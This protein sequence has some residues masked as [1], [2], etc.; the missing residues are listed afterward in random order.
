[1]RLGCFTDIVM[2]LISHPVGDVQ[3]LPGHLS[4]DQPRLGPQLLSRIVIDVTP[5]RID[6]SISQ[7]EALAAGSTSAREY[8]RTVDIQCL[9]PLRSLGVPSYELYSFPIGGSRFDGRDP[10][11]SRMNWAR[12]RVVEL[13]PA[14]LST[15]KRAETLIWNING[16]DLDGALDPIF[17]RLLPLHRL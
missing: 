1:M 10:D 13:L 3:D 5:R 15:L 8:V 17:A 16:G 9:S 11:R 2:I 12:A 6:V 7:L 4:T 14:A